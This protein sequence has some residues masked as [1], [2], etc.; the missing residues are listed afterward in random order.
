ML[1]TAE[2]RQRLGANIVLILGFLMNSAG[3][4]LIRPMIVRRERWT[5][6]PAPVRHRKFS[7]FAVVVEVDHVSPWVSKCS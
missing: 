3:N 5:G 7:G 6:T 2:T 4:S 1:D